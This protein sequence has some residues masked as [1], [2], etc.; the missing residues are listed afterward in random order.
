MWHVHDDTN[1]FFLALDGRFDVAIRGTDGSETTV[2]LRQGDRSSCR[3][4]TDHTP[5]SLDGSIL[6]SEPSGTS[7]T[8]DRHDGAIP[9]HV[10]STTSHELNRVQNPS[11]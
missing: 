9:S 8:G 4:G 6:M 2:T 1:E 5:S 3:K 11:G 10:D 7:A